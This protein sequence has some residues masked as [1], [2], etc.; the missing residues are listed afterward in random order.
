MP[1]DARG[2]K[3]RVAACGPAPSTALT[4][5]PP[6]PLREGG[7]LAFSRPPLGGRSV[8]GEVA[9]A[10]LPRARGRGTARSAVEGASEGR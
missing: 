7:S 10:I 1:P 2:I 8:F 3:A 4:R 5:G 9:T 6:P